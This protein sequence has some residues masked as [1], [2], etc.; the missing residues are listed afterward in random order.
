MTRAGEK[1]LDSISS[2][3]NGAQPLTFRQAAIE[4]AEW[5]KITQSAVPFLEAQLLLAR[6]IGKSGEYIMAH[7]E[8]IPTPPQWRLFR[9]LV[10]RR[11]RFEPIAYILG[12]KEFYSLT[13]Q[14]DKRALIPRPETELLVETAL[15]IFP[16]GGALS[17]LEI[18]AG[19]GIISICLAKS[20]SEWM[21][22]ATDVSSDALDLARQNAVIHQAGERISFILADL[23]PPGAEKFDLLISNPPYIPFGQKGLAPDI[24]L[25]E[26]EVALYGGEDGLDAIRKIIHHAPDRLAPGGGI[27]MEIGYGQTEEVAGLLERTGRFNS[28]TVIPDYQG[29]G[30]VI[31]AKRK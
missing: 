19:T 12:E 1:P 18:G 10:E 22:T 30:R 14:V 9:K 20:R 29:I 25:Y 31:W 3:E 2:G 16:S 7:P 15:D 27:A 11:A 4:A 28:I 23:F 17:I 24:T 13:F 6:A 26:P 5:I 8:Q 21:F